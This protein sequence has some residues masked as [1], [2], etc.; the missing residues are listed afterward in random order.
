MVDNF[1]LV[2]NINLGGTVYRIHHLVCERLYH[3][4]GSVRRLL[5]GYNTVTTL[6][7]SRRTEE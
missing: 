5:T 3:R 6:S 2:M 1:D 7:F 4:V